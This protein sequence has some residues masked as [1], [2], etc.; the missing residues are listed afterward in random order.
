M[1]RLRPP[2]PARRRLRGLTL[3]VRPLSRRRPPGVLRILIQP[4]LQFGTYRLQG[5]AA[6]LVAAYH[7]P[8]RSLA[9]GRDAVPQLLGQGRLSPH[10]PALH[11]A[12]VAGTQVW[13]V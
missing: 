6:P 11:S 13:G 7:E 2:L 12:A 1:P 9:L 10:R 8:D 5:R 3:D 4:L